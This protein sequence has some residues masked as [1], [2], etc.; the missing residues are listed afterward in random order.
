[1]DGYTTVDLQAS[2]VLPESGWR[3][4]AGVQNIFDADF[5]FFDAYSG[6]DSSKVDFRR[7]VAFV[8]ISK[9]FSW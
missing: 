2:Y 8:D 3:I 5:P 1:M 7:R 6:V 9:E 4:T